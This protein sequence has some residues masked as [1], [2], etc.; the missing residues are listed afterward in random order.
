VIGC[1]ILLPITDWPVVSG[2]G[3][4]PLR[5]GFLY[6]GLVGVGGGPNSGE[7]ICRALDV[8]AGVVENMGVDQGRTDV[9]SRLG[10]VLAGGDFPARR[11]KFPVP[12][13]REFEATIVERLGNLGPNSLKG[14]RNRRIPCIFAA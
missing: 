8:R 13:Y 4:R 6:V 5:S 12:D 1:R 14:V 9:G 7:S 10:A 11:E 2:V 3:G